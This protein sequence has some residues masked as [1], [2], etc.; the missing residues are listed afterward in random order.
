MSTWPAAESAKPGSS[1]NT[2]T[3][4]RSWTGVGSKNFQ[5]RRD[6][7][8]TAELDQAGAETL[9]AGIPAP[10]L[11]LQAVDTESQAFLTDWQLGDQATVSFDGQTIT[12]IIREV[13]INLDGNTPPLITPT[14]G[15]RP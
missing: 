12:D 15:G 2:K 13:T 14:V 1:S 6:T 4:N 10:E 11:E 3:P 9:A 7:A 8:D 5:D